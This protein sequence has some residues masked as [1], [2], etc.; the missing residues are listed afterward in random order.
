MRFTED[1][2]RRFVAKVTVR[3]PDA[4]WPWLAY[5]D[6]GG[7]GR[8]WD[9]DKLVQAHRFAWML[10]N[11]SI[12]A[13]LLVLHRC[14]APGCVNPGHLFLGTQAD[15]LADMRAKGRAVYGGNRGEWNGHAKLTADEVRAIY[16]RYHAGGT[17]Q[18]K[19]ATEY[20]V[21]VSQISNITRGGN[22]RH[23]TS[24]A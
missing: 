14:D 20:G 19:L 10:T 16:A 3:E 11:G 1:V 8:F 24:S 12:P 17:F 15:N 21:C 6:R 2:A 22:W 7:Y 4:C 9:G 5:T 13:G 18:R 23:V